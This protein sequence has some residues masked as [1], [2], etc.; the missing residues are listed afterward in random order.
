MCGIS[1]FRG[2]SD[3]LPFSTPAAWQET[4]DLDAVVDEEL[5]D[6]LC[7]VYP[8]HIDPGCDSWC[9]L[10]DKHVRLVSVVDQWEAIEQCS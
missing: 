6:R 7:M 4:P 5:L 2:L 9:G 10:G 3:K 1:F 8:E